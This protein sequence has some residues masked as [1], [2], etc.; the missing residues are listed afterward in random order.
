[1][2]VLLIVHAFVTVMMTGVIWFVQ[3]VHYPLMSRVPPEAMC[4]YAREHARRTTWIVAPLMIAEAAIAA[5]LLVMPTRLPPW[6]LIAGA[7]LVVAA[8][9]ATFGLSV[10]CHNRLGREY[11]AATV[12]RLVRTNWIRTFAWTARSVIALSLIAWIRA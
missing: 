10:P 1:M 8:W 6:L 3:L 4:V 5:G 2:A 9:V 12:R 11:D 7:A